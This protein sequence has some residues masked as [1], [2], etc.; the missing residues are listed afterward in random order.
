M[1]RRVLTGGL[2]VAIV[3][4][5]GLGVWMW[6]NRP[7]DRS[8]EAFCAHMAA[9]QGLDDALALSDPAQISA[10]SDALDDAAQV[11]PEEIRGDVEVLAALVQ[12][13]D[14]AV[15]DSSDPS[16]ALDDALRA[17]QAALTASEPAGEAVQRYVAD[18]CDLELN[19]SNTSAP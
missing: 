19:P 10:Q 18:N 12:T 5:A 3:V 16:T 8:V 11:A 13:I 9:A 14:E 6:R 2:V 15:A 1:T 7:P 17:N 4:A